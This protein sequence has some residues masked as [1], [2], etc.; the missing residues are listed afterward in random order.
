MVEK[1]EMAKD[2]IRLPIKEC[3]IIIKFTQ[4]EDGESNLSITNNIPLFELIGILDTLRV[5]YVSD[6]VMIINKT[7]I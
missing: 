7:N 5:K 3:S 6:S 2:I 4:F 1:P